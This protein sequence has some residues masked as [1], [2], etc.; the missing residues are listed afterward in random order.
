M[1]ATKPS[2][3]TSISACLYSQPKD[4]GMLD[5]VITDALRIS[6]FADHSAYPE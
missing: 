3:L 4:I 6:F 1:L 5:P 2:L